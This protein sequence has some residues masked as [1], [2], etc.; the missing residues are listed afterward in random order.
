MN[1]LTFQILMYT[2]SI[3][4]RNRHEI[5]PIDELDT[6]GIDY[7]CSALLGSE[8]YV[9]LAGLSLTCEKFSV[10]VSRG[11]THLVSLRLIVVYY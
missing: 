9:Q 8:E 4:L 6:P 5:I 10:Y 11:A 3:S 1:L 7:I 2:F